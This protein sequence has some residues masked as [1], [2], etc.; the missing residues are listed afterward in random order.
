MQFFVLLF[1]IPVSLT[2]QDF[3]KDWELRLLAR[4][5]VYQQAYE[6]FCLDR[7]NAQ[8]QEAQWLP[9]A[10]LD[11]SY[12]LSKNEGAEGVVYT[13]SSSLSVNLSQKLPWGGYLSGKLLHSATHLQGSDTPFGYSSSGSVSLVAPLQLWD[14]GFGVSPLVSWMKSQEASQKAVMGQWNAQRL[15][16]IAQTLKLFITTLI[17]Q[18]NQENRARLLEWYSVATQADESLWAAGR[19]SSFELTEK[20]RKRADAHQSFLQGQKQLLNNQAEVKLWG[21]SPEKED[22]EKWLEQWE[23]VLFPNRPAQAWA[24]DAESQTLLQSAASQWQEEQSQLPQIN[25]S[26]TF[27]PA[28][29][30][31][32]KT[33]IPQALEAYWWGSLP[34]NWS[35]SASLRWPLVP[36][37]PVYQVSEKGF[38][39]R[40]GLE[41]QERNLAFRQSQWEESQ[42]RSLELL[43]KAAGQA[44][45]RLLLEKDRDELYLLKAQSGQ[46]SPQERD[47]QSIQAETARLDWLRARLELLVY[48]ITGE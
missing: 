21:L 1:L 22:L 30:V 29:A 2:A 40:R 27:T 14:Q 25:I 37:D 3:L 24:L 28:P 26:Y 45:D 5:P 47:Y 46:I 39:K 34:W 35:L 20:S 48:G 19:L 44:K 6:N 17:D 13:Q 10:S 16:R 8:A 4:D 9:G 36:W 18:K 43:Q 11:P 33:D 38:R 23:L 41:A 31:A 15:R 42:T 7:G 32:E 12:T